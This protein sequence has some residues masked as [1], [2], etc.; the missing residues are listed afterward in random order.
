MPDVSN[1]YC[2]F[3]VKGVF[4]PEEITQL[5]NVQPTQ[6]W[7]IGDDRKNKI[8][9]HTFALW[10][11]GKTIIKYPELEIQCVKAIR[12]LIGKENLLLELKQKHDVSFTLEIVPS[13]V[14][15]KKP[16]IELGKEVIK[17]CYLTDT[18]IDIDMYVYPFS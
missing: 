15:G 3:A 11:T 17:F 10:E 5:L 12:E 14:N 4:D 18:Y 8:D 13:I 7:A 1:C 16:N 2:Y 6:S 9:Q